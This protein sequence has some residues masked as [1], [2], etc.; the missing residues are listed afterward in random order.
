MAAQ[1]PSS[2]SL[3][4]PQQQQQQQAQLQQDAS[5]LGPIARARDALRAVLPG[6]GTHQLGAAIE[7]EEEDVTTTEA[8]SVKAPDPAKLAEEPFPQPHC[9]LLNECIPETRERQPNPTRPSSWLGP[10]FKPSVNIVTSL[11]VFA[12]ADNIFSVV[13][14]YGPPGSTCLQSPAWIGG[15]VSHHVPGCGLIAMGLADAN[16]DKLYVFK[17]NYNL[18]LPISIGKE[19][20]QIRLWLCF[21]TLPA[22]GSVNGTIG[23]TL[24]Y[25][26]LWDMSR[27]GS[28]MQV[29]VD[30]SP[31][32]IGLNL[33][34]YVVPH[35]NNANNNKLKKKKPT[36]ANGVKKRSAVHKKVKMHKASGGKSSK[37]MKKM[38]KKKHRHSSSSNHDPLAFLR[39][40]AAF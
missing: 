32:G 2:S 8:F 28:Q 19:S 36:K 3:T 1:P 27:L 6:S 37:K 13:L 11:N 24:R 18:D 40:N 21:H 5:D 17:K 9:L 25:K 15:S 23:V 31:G 12:A 7:E 22:G 38:M 33:L 20:S 10:G 14:E 34:D 4:N 39:T 29:R 30:R 35:E 16:G 26:P